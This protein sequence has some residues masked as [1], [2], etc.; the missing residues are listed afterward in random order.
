MSEANELKGLKEIQ[1]TKEIKELKDRVCEFECN[2]DDMTGEELAHAAEILIR[3]GAKDVSL[4]PIGMKKGR[5]GT[6]L[7]VMCADDE[8]ERQRILGLIFRYTTTIG[9]REVVSERYILKRE[10]KTVETPYGRVRCKVSSGY[11]V[12]KAKIEYEDLAR[13][14]E[15]RKISISAAR[16]LVQPY[17][18]KYINGG[19]LYFA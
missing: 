11:G 12:R 9:V 6:L 3:E 19:E 16:E 10:E 5:P 18:N 17:V 13:I 2:I 8:A 4:S 15:N 14:A 1:K 7:T